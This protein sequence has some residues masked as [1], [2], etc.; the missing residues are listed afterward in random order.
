MQ[1][2]D[3]S[4]VTHA[5]TPPPRRATTQRPP[6]RAT[7]RERRFPGEI[8]RKARQKEETQRARERSEGATDDTSKTREN[9]QEE[10]VVCRR[11]LGG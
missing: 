7:P 8:D 10:E 4:C 3:A 1:P 5:R 2:I 6:V 11:G 9:S